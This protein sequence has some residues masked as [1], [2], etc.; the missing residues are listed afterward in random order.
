[1]DELQRKYTDRGLVVVAVNLDTKPESLDKFLA[2]LSVSFAIAF[3][4][5]GS[6]AKAYKVKAMPSSYII[7]REGNI[8]STQIGFQEKDAKTL[9]KQVVEL[10]GK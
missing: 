10:L 7:D 9:E 4:P 6:V 5:A 3:D 1:M 8:A 2:K